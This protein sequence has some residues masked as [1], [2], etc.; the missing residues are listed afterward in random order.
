MA[1]GDE[2][3]R[4]DQKF[5]VVSNEVVKGCFSAPLLY[6]LAIAFDLLHCHGVLLHEVFKWRQVVAVIVLEEPW[7]ALE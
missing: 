3:Q 4:V 5:F 2:I 6:E 7:C 1:C